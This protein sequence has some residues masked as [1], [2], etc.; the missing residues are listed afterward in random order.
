MKNK[1]E[2]FPTTLHVAELHDSVNP[3]E[4]DQVKTI[5]ALQQSLAENEDTVR[6]QQQ[7][8]LAL[9]QTI[10]SQ[11]NTN[12]EH[13][14]TINWL[15]QKMLSQQQSAVAYEE[16]VKGLQQTVLENEASNKALQRAHTSA[17]DWVNKTNNSQ[18][19]MLAV[20]DEQ[21][22]KVYA[23]N[24][25]LEPEYARL[26]VIEAQ[27]LDIARVLQRLDRLDTTV[28]AALDTQ[29]E[30]LTDNNNNDTASS[31]AKRRR[32]DL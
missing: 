26:R 7:T 11:Q 4:S 6:G 5:V 27:H 28:T 20:L 31:A 9:Q 13:E 24:L 21:K 32:E 19:Q 12:I 17:I 15:Q 2:R 10:V 8:I 3:I 30:A 23:R 22:A 1:N 16:T 14:D 29:H 25:F 18:A